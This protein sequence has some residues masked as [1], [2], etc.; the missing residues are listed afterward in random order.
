MPTIVSSRPSLIFGATAAPRAITVASLVATLSAACDQSQTPSKSRLDWPERSSSGLSDGSP[1]TVAADNFRTGWYPN[2]PMLDPMTIGGDSFRQVFDTPVDGQVYSQPLVANGV[3]LIVTE[4]NW[5]YG[6][7]PT[8]GDILWSRNLGVPWRASDLGCGDFEATIGVTGTPVIDPA[9]STAYLLAKTYADADAS[10]SAWYAHALDLMTGAERTG[11]PVQVQGTAANAPIRSFDAGVQMQRPGLLLLD[12][13]V[14]AG[15]GSQCDRGAYAGWI[16][17]ITTDGRLSSLWTT[18]A[19]VPLSTG[20]AI[21]QSGGGLISDGPGQILFATGNDWTGMR[22]PTPGAHPPNALGEAVVRLV[23]ASDGSLRAVD[24]FSPQDAEMLDAMDLDLGSG[25]PVALPADPFGTT[26]HTNLLVQIG[27]EGKGYL[28]DRDRLG[29]ISQGADA[30]DDVLQV[31]G[32]DGAVWSKPSVWPGDGGYLYVPATAGPLHAYRYHLT[33]D[34]QPALELAGA[35]PDAF[36]FG[37]S[38]PVITSNGTQSGSALVWMTW[39]SG[40]DGLGGQLRAYDPIPRNGV[41]AL[42][43]AA[44]IGQSAKFAMPGV[45]NGHI[46]VGTRD[47]HALGFGKTPVGTP[48]GG[49]NDASAPS[50]DSSPAGDDA[51]VNRQTSNPLPSQTTPSDGGCTCDLSRTQGTPVGLLFLLLVALSRRRRV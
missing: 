2:Q 30:G 34:D 19:A 12:G 7:D 31:F 20:A 46:Y 17:G 47:G 4:T 43:F 39:P 1:I 22:I 28:L 32:P 9:S 15:F 37:S 18:E 11:F 26:E 41:L 33:P 35:S 5:T 36:G 21:W 6:L 49:P 42:L 48:G 29:G 16:V 10:E 13:V 45:G 50:L 3:L 8:S 14:Y 38:S 24:F 25:A 44:N 51:S 23:A 27:K 40:P